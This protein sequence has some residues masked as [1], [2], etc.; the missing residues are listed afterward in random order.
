VSLSFPSEV[1]NA[2]G[3]ETSNSGNHSG[4][5]LNTQGNGQISLVSLRCTGLGGNPP[6]TSTC[7][8][9]Q[10]PD[11]VAPG[12][13]YASTPSPSPTL[14]STQLAAAKAMAIANGTYFGSGSCPTT[15]S[16]LVGSP[17]YVEG[18]CNI[19]INGGGTINNPTGYL[20]IVN[21]TLYLS[22]STTYNGV[23]YA[24]N[25]QGCPNPSSSY[26]LNGRGDVVQV[27]GNATVSGGVT[28]DGNGTI[29][30]GSSGQGNVT[31]NPAAFTPMSAYGGAAATPN[32]FRQLPAGQ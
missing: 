26:C 3:L 4:P 25:Q 1:I 23:I 6:N 22:G 2:N 16:Q 19:N 21:G 30:L 29:Y 15:A 13:S 18:P 32:T 14:T 27:Q 9:I 7:A 28:I 10:R 17:V 11:Q 31:Y 8:Q 24:V 20:V 12:P 5:I